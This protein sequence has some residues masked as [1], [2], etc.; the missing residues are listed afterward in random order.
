M[1]AIKAEGVVV[2]VSLSPHCNEKFPA[3][4]LTQYNLYQ[5]SGYF[6]I[7]SDLFEKLYK[8]L[9]NM[10]NFIGA[11]YA[12]H[13]R[14]VVFHVVKNVYKPISNCNRIDKKIFICHL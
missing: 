10:M 11:N 3:T 1:N 12:Y 13:Y 8:Q 4:R 6:T 2:S 14:R 5:L 9:I 7:H